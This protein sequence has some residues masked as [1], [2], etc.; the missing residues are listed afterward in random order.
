MKTNISNMQIKHV[1]PGQR[2]RFKELFCAIL[3]ILIHFSIDELQD[4]HDY[5]DEI[6]KS[7]LV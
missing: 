1:P 4:L 6:K 5:V 2:K 3:D 7:K